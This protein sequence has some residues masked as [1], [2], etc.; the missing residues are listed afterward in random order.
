MCVVV[1]HVD[2]I[3]VIDEDVC[4]GWEVLGYQQDGIEFN[5]EDIWEPRSLV[6]M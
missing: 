1:E 5:C 2:T 4:V 6:V 3:E